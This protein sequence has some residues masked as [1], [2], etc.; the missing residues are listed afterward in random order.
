MMTGNATVD[1]A[2]STAAIGALLPLGLP[3][4]PPSRRL[5]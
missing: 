1:R 3:T 2:G 4:S 5:R